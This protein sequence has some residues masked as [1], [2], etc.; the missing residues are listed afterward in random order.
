M[1]RPEVPHVSREGILSPDGDQFHSLFVS[2]TN[3]LTSFWIN[4]PKCPPAQWS[5]ESLPD[6]IPNTIRA[7]GDVP[8]DLPALPQASDRLSLSASHYFPK[9]RSRYGTVPNIAGVR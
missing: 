2:D 9:Q 1:Y 8:R 6:Q 7:D 3:G 5:L 4:D